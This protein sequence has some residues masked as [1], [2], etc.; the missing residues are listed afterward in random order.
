MDFSDFLAA[1][2]EDLPVSAVRF[3]GTYMQID[4]SKSEVYRLRVMAQKRFFDSAKAHPKV[5]FFKGHFSGAG[6]EKGVD[7]HLAVDMAIGAVTDEY[8]EPLS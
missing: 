6:K 3:Y 7:V 5:S 1:V 2:E 4:T 8:D